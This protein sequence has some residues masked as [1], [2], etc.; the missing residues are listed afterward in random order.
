MT[1]HAPTPARLAALRHEGVLPL[2]TLAVRSILSVAVFGA[3][4]MSG[5]QWQELR[6]HV[7]LLAGSSLPLDSQTLQGF[8][9]VCALIGFRLFLVAGGLA[10]VFGIISVFAQTRFFIQ[11]SLAS[12]RFER[13]FRFGEIFKRARSAF[14]LPHLTLAAACGVVLGLGAASIA[15]NRMWYLSPTDPRIEIVETIMRIAKFLSQ[16]ALVALVVVAGLSWT[17]SKRLFLYRHRMTSE[18]LESESRG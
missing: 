18:E 9:T 7:T 1:E 6:E 5:P 8:V 2:S 4:L 16:C 12:F 17:T 11:L 13:L 10:L 3:F 15:F 14:R